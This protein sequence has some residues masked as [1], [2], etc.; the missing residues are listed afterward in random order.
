MLLKACLNGNRRPSE[1]AALPVG[2]AELARDAVAVRAA[3]A[4]AL[5]LHV[6]DHDGADTLAAD[7]TAAVLSAVRSA[8]PGLP[9]GLTTGAW[10][11]PDP[12][13]RLACVASWS[14]LPDFASVNWHEE[15]AD[16]LA[17]LLLRLGIAVEAGLWHGDA[18]AAWGGSRVRDRCLRI[19]I[20]LPDGL[21]A[22]QTA[23]TADLLLARVRDLI[24][25]RIPVLVHG[26]G[27]SAWPAVRY[28]G[29]E[30]LD[31]RIGLEDVLHRPD[32]TRA[33][34]NADLV[35][36]ARRLLG[37]ADG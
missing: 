9:V 25:T 27:S 5:H 1:H 37:D 8:A 26:E 33:E 6:K 22:L 21:D 24:G 7:P 18:V 34:D 28:A 11:A 10:A 12:A 3:G 30:G 13:D 32:G 29:A 17:E 36:Q 14:A 15:G 4:G 23:T 31:T 16:E 35:T 19:L 2:P 20:E